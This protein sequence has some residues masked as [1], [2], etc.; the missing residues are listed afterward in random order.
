MVLLFLFSMK[1]ISGAHSYYSLVAWLTGTQSL[2]CDET[3]PSCRKCVRLN[4]S[5][6]YPRAPAASPSASEGPTGLTTPTEPRVSPS[7]AP[8]VLSS[9]NAATSQDLNLHDLELLHNFCTFT[10]TTLSNDG[11][12]RNF[13][14]YTVVRL[15]VSC[16]YVMRAILA[17]SALHMALHQPIRKD[18]LINHAITY[19]QIASRTAM[20][21]MISIKP[22][23]RENLWIFSILTM[24]FGVS[25]SFRHFLFLET[26]C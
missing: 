11:A 6:S 4:V 8:H 2:Q 17:V 5:C 15:G 20:Q 24:Y 26:S 16:D 23:D 19:H 22:E 10:Y 9:T 13:W 12:L 3:K 21:L 1:P 7:P 25:I 18:F 14:K